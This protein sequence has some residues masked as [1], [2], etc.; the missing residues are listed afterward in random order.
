MCFLGWAKMLKHRDQKF[1]DLKNKDIYIL[2]AQKSQLENF[3]DLWVALHHRV[4]YRLM[5]LSSCALGWV[6]VP[7][8]SQLAK[9]GQRKHA[10]GTS[11]FKCP[12]I[13]SAQ[14]TSILSMPHF[15][16]LTGHAPSNKIKYRR[17]GIS[18]EEYKCK[19]KGIVK[20]RWKKSD[21]RK[22]KLGQTIF[23]RVGREQ[24]IDT[25]ELKN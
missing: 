22:K 11:L 6:Q 8:I 1:R 13:E 17:R 5:L 21:E 2:P 3:P 7:L 14:I 25:L 24:T 12:N 23:C 19:N 16:I 10:E 18:M 9:A 15:Y 20:K 4:I